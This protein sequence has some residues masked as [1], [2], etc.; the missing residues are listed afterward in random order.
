MQDAA[1]DE[2]VNVARNATEKRSYSEE[3]NRGREH[4]ACAESIGHPAAD[5]NEHRQAQRITRQHSLH[6][7][8]GDGERLR[9]GGDGGVQNRRVERFH[10]ESHGDKPRQQSLHGFGRRR[11]R[12]G[13]R[14]G[15]GWNHT[16]ARRLLGS[17]PF[18]IPNRRMMSFQRRA[19]KTAKGLTAN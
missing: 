18:P 10:E 11:G 2:D 13:D 6:A 17:A 16:S 9:D 14:A 8:R 12:H 3:A 19:A 15:M 5:R 1:R 4:P 7:E